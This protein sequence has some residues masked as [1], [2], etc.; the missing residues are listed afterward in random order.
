VL[1]P[2]DDFPVHQ[3]A[4]PMRFVA[5]SDRNFYDRYYFN[6][7]PCRDELFLTA[8]LGQY[9]NL[10]VADAFVAVTRHGV[11]RV[12]RTSRLLGDDRADTTV[13]PV[14][15][16]VLEGLR[17]LRL[18]ADGHH[19]DIAL[20]VVW[21]AAVPAHAEPRHLIRRGARRT[22]DSFR[23]VQTGRWTGWLRVAG[24]RFDVTPERWWGGR[25]RS[26]GIR[27]VGEPEPPGWRQ[28]QEAGG[29]LW[30]Y[31]TMQFD[32]FSLIYIVQEDRTGARTL[33]EGVRLWPAASNLP[34]EPLGR[35]EHDLTFLPGSRRLGHATLSFHPPAGGDPL[36]VQATPIGA[37]YLALGTGYGTEEDW[38][39]GMYQGPFVE[40]SRAYDLADPAV[41]ARTY[42]LIDNLARF[43]VREPGGPQTAVGYGLLEHAVL[44]PNDRYGF[45]SRP[46]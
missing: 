16:E 33:E 8:G 11:Q 1:S 2:L 5:T 41:A 42:G 25:D 36:V 31:C 17:R 24:E 46:S 13:G 34:P 9:P 21:D 30:L 29:F 3:I 14:S 26:W 44:G 20:D 22:T 18:R 12:L 27:P 45:E 10:G 39:H 15:V 19:D 6:L 43:E 4:E 7:H 32:R 38:R 35:P 37:C 40:Q 28:G 23:F